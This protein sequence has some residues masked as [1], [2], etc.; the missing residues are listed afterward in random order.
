MN[1]QTVVY[2]EYAGVIV[3]GEFRSL[4]L[5]EIV[6]AGEELP[7]FKE[8]YNS[9]FCVQ[10]DLTE[11]EDKPVLAHLYVKEK[12]DLVPVFHQLLDTFINI[13][14]VVDSVER[15]VAMLAEPQSVN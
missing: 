3:V 2:C 13:Q 6:E 7:G 8:N 9:Y 5:L 15:L 12:R 10:V 4:R 14:V 11:A 1:E